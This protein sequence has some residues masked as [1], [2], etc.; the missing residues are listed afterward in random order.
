MTSS[1][2]PIGHVLSEQCLH[3]ECLHRNREIPSHALDPPSMFI[4]AA[5]ITDHR[6]SGIC[7][8][9]RGEPPPQMHGNIAT[10][11][12]LAQRR[13]TNPVQ[14]V[15]RDDPQFIERRPI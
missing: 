6:D 12:P 5:H 7:H 13:V 4:R 8:F 9:R 10:F 14:F 2:K 15:L 1:I 11:T 3:R